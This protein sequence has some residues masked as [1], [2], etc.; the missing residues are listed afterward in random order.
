MNDT[1]ELGKRI[2]EIR[3]KR[4]LREF[5]EL[6]GISHTY[7]DCIEKGFD[8]RTGKPIRV[9]SEVIYKLANGTKIDPVQLF[10]LSLRDIDDSYKTYDLK[11]DPT[12]FSITKISSGNLSIL[13]RLM[14]EHEKY[15]Y[16]NIQEF[17]GI[18]PDNYKSWER[19]DSLPNNEDLK[20]LAQLYGVSTAFF[21]DGVDKKGAFNLLTTSVPLYQSIACGFAMFVGDNV[22]EYITL[23]VSLLHQNKEYFAQ[24]AK[25]DS[26]IDENIQD[27]DL[28]V[29][30]KTTVVQNGQIGCFCIDE[31]M[32][33]CKKFY[34]DD[35]S[36]IIT[37]QP[38]NK[39]YAPIIVT[40]ETMNF[41]VV[42]K[43]ALVI[44]KR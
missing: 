6:C 42:G 41:H 18:D 7:L 21:G 15:S 14:R 26:M 2:R 22:E 11:S 27:G 9:T 5:A 24:Y 4:S 40:V 38:A 23:P 13:L 25:G 31:N 8:F 39:T 16:D 43:L 34:K 20:S 35:A 30:E 33:T 3:G 37:L 17:S 12:S 28:L 1:K 10:E 19:G 44:N 36:A 29:F 32:A